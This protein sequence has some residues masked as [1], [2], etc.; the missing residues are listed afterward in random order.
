MLPGAP[1]WHARSVVAPHILL[2]PDRPPP[3]PLVPAGCLLRPSHPAD[4][5]SLGALY[6]HSYDPGQ[7]CA[8]LAEA[9]AD[10]RAAFAG[11]YGELC[12]A[13][14]L[15]A[16]TAD[17]Q[18]VAAIQVV[19]RA[20]WPG[21]PDWLFVIELFAARAHRRRGLARSLIIR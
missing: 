8:S 4:I 21:T 6:F 1:T 19:K 7:A 5:D 17:Q 15:V 12:P 14:S 13:A 3:A 16:V 20:S 9:T 18:I 2:R 10:I 11:E